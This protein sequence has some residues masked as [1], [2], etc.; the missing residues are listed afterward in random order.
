MVVCVVLDWNTHKIK[1]VLEIIEYIEPAGIVCVNIR[2]PLM[3]ISVRGCCFSTSSIKSLTFVISS[4]DSEQFPRGEQ[5]RNSL[6]S[7]SRVS[8]CLHL[9][10]CI[11]HRKV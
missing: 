3:K 9:I 11:L 4:L 1:G 8:L 5:T 7:S 10:G 2:A 6:E